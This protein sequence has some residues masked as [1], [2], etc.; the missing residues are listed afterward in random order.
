MAYPVI[1]SRRMPYDIDGSAVGYR[2]LWGSSPATLLSNG[3]A[4]WL[5]SSPR[6]TLNGQSNSSRYGDVYNG[7]CVGFWFFFPEQREVTH[8]AIANMIGKTSNPASQVL[9]GSA[10]T[11]NGMDGTWETPVCT[12][13]TAGIADGDAWRD[14]I[15]TVSFS[16]PMKCIRYARNVNTGTSDA[17]IA[18]FHIYGFK[19]AGQTPDDI[20]FTDING[21]EIASLTDWGD[22]PEG[23]TE[24]WWFK[25]KNASTTKIANAVN[26]QLN[27]ADFAI[28]LSPDGPWV[29]VIDIT[30]IAAGSL[31]STIY[32]RNKLDPPTLI[33]GPRAARCIVT[34]GSWT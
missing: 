14:N 25:L 29:A 31:S 22:Q 24:I 7:N 17:S 13:P 23:T 18:L 12:I 10:D 32:V 5:D 1:N 27:N 16:G 15:F 30:S 9:Q 19:A 11:T 21:N 33:L 3:P 26:L 8:M 34:V 6:G 28:A 2:E 4:S 20:V